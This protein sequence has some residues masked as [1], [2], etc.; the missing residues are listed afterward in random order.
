MSCVK[1]E[2]LSS[3]E[4]HPIKDFVRTLFCPYCNK[5]RL[6]HIG[7]TAFVVLI[8]IMPVILYS[9]I[10][11]DFITSRESNGEMTTLGYWIVIVLWFSFIGTIYYYKSKIHEK[12]YLISELNEQFNLD[13][14]L[15]SMQEKN[16]ASQFYKS[17]NYRHLLT[18]IKNAVIDFNKQG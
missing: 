9:F 11:W 7:V 16:N 6:K 3:P 10:K 5:K 18:G 12:N 1:C 13:D 15:K 17:N 8:F 2:D 4:T 14:K